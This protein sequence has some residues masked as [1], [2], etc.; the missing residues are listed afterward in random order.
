M[1]PD[2]HGRPPGPGWR[3]E[4]S[5]LEGTRDWLVAVLIGVLFIVVAMV[6][7]FVAFG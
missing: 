7:A 3:T 4:L 2:R 1:R 5:G 6:I